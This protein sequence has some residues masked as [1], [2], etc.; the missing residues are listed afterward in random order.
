MAFLTLAMPKDRNRVT[1]SAEN[2]LTLNVSNDSGREVVFERDVSPATGLYDGIYLTFQQGEGAGDLQADI[3]HIGIEIVGIQGWVCQI[4]SPRT[5]PFGDNTPFWCLRPTDGMKVGPGTAFTINIS[6]IQCNSVTGTTPAKISQQ[7]QGE[8]EKAA[9]DII[10]CSKAAVDKFEINSRDYNI[11]DRVTFQWVLHGTDGYSR[12]YLD[13]AL[14]TGG[15]CDQQIH[16]RAYSLT[17]ENGSSYIVKSTFTPSFVFFESFKITGGN[18][19]N[20]TLTVEWKTR[21]LKDCCLQYEGTKEAV[22]IA[23]GSKTVSIADKGE[24]LEIQ[25]VM[26]EGETGAVV[27]VQK[28]VYQFPEVITFQAYY[29]TELISLEA[30]GQMEIIPADC[31]PY[32]PPDPP[33]PPPPP[34]VRNVHISWGSKNAIRCELAG[35][36]GVKDVKGDIDAQLT[37][38]PEGPLN[39]IDKYGFARGKMNEKG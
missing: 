36:P 27:P 38:V 15:S 8:T 33:P 37:C 26:T 4:C 24:S 20:K 18:G 11:G 22:N 34:L 32:N 12:V 7:S 9:L 6:N 3:S 28:C 14:Q 31:P 25:L 30:I 35:V 5:I 13:G 19:A 23:G 39:A 17:V 1:V 10:K 29:T 2:G 16:N 21:N